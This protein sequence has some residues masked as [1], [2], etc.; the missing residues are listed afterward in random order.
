MTKDDIAAL[1]AHEIF[2][3]LEIQAANNGLSKS[4]KMYDR[5]VIATCTLASLRVT[6]MLIEKKIIE[7][8][9]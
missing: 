7:V 9:D 2:A 3:E 8:K 4:F 5:L 1:I 6:K